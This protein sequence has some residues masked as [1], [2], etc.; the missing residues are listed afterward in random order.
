M[1]DNSGWLHTGDV[2]YYDEDEHFFIVDRLKN[3]IKFKGHQ[4]SWSVD[5]SWY[6]QLHLVYNDFEMFYK[7]VL[8]FS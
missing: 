7:W 4:V 1:I 5:Y 6:A 8:F 2:G 3:V